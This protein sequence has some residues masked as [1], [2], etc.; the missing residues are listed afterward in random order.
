MLIKL[1]LLSSLPWIS[2]PRN[3]TE[4]IMENLS[5]KYIHS[6]QYLGLILAEML[7]YFERVN[8]LYESLLKCFEISYHVKHKVISMGHPRFCFILM[9]GSIHTHTHTHAPIV[10][11]LHCILHISVLHKGRNL[12]DHWFLLIVNINISCNT[13]NCNMLIFL[14]FILHAPFFVQWAAFASLKSELFVTYTSVVCTYITLYHV[15][16]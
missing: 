7:N 14:V 12:D 5:I 11:R 2:L 13:V 10:M 6:F 4:L 15:L 8:N 9:P 3:F 16:L 1:T